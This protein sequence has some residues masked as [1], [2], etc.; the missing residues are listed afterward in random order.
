MSSRKQLARLRE[1][2][3]LRK[4]RKII[5]S[6]DKIRFVLDVL[7]GKIEIA[8]LCQKEGIPIGLFN[9]WVKEF[10]DA[11][12]RRLTGELRN[13]SASGEFHVLK[14]ENLE[15]K[16]LVAELTLEVRMLKKNLNGSV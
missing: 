13:E 16:H 5:S 10:I 7:Q 3:L 12:K 15:L 8:E 6:E 4:N 14:K 11:G 2:D 9:S 1:K